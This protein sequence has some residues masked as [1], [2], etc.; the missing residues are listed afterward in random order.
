MKCT[1]IIL[2]I[3]SYSAFAQP[4]NFKLYNTANG[5]S[6]NNVSSI[7]KD[8][9][10]FIWVGT[11]NGLNRFD[12]NAFD[13]F[14]N[15]PNDSNTIASNYIQSV[16][17]TAKDKLWV[18]TAN[19]ISTFN[20]T[21]QH[22]SNY[23]PDTLAMPKIGQTFTCIE[24]DANN[25]I[26]VGGWYDLLIFNPT[27]KKFKTSG[28]ANYIQKVKP[29]NGNHRRVVI[30]S[31]YKKSNNSFWVLT[32]YGLFSVDINSLEFNFYPYNKIDDYYGCSISYVD[33]RQ[34]LW[35]ATY[36]KG[37]VNFDVLNQK[38]TNYPL[39][40]AYA[41][42]AGWNNANSIQQYN[43]DTLIV[44]SNKCILL[45]DKAQQKFLNTITQKEYSELPPNTINYIYK[46]DKSFWI[47]SNYGITN[48]QPSKNNF[49]FTSLGNTQ[50]VYR[51]FYSSSKKEFAL[52]DFF[53]QSG[54]YNPQT[55]KYTRLKTNPAAKENGVRAYLEINKDSAYLCTDENLYF[56]NPST[57][58]IKELS[59]PSKVI[60]ENPSTIRNIVKD[61][62][63]VLWIRI[64]SQGI[65]KYNPTLQTGAYVNI[66]P[67]EP[68]TDYSA[69]YYDKVS[70]CIF[71]AASNQGIYIYDIEKNNIKKHLLNI[72]PSQKGASISCIVGD[73]DGNIFLSDTYNGL[74][75][76]NS[77]NN[78]FKRYTIFDG[79]QSNNCS[80][81][82]VDNK[83]IW[84][85][86]NTG[87]SAFD[88]KTHQFK[89]FG[90]GQNHIGFA[91]YVTTDGEGN[92]YQPLQNGYLSWST[93]NV[94]QPGPIGKIY[95]RQCVVNEKLERIDSVYS[96]TADK[97]NVSFLFGYLL[98]NNNSPVQFEYLLNDKN[99]NAVGI[100]NKISFSKLPPNSYTLQ[101][102][103]KSNP[104]QI[105]TIN[106]TIVPPFYKKWWFVAIA[107]ICLSLLIY[108][109]VKNRITSIKKQ[110]TLKQKIAETEM[111]A[112]RAQMNP[113][114][115]FNAISSIDNFILDND[116]TNASNYLNKFAKLIRNILDNSK[117]EVVPFWKDWETL[118][119][120]LQLEQLR[121][122][123]SFAYTLHADENLL[124]GHYKIPPLIIQP[125]IENAIHHGL[126]PLQ[127][128]KGKLT[129]TATIQNNILQYTIEDNGIGRKRAAENSMVKSQH[130]SYGMQLTQQRIDLFNNQQ[131]N[132]VTIKDIE[133]G[134]KTGTIV[135]VFLKV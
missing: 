108:L 4:Y 91:D 23:S 118:N 134:D 69:L 39:P 77:I 28:W 123:D 30:L 75:V 26:W 9:K 44:A 47:L 127:N 100:N 64:R 74:I 20:E 132:N 7:I 31:I 67:V 88:I 112:L 21:T 48:M 65:Y 105:F 1:A 129:I 94:L 133:D 18:T 122:N 126:K 97:N 116:A 43:A 124:N 71:V 19:G 59:L 131:Q 72:E 114:F 55:K 78:T 50:M 14:Y 58:T 52:G 128:K 110:A 79:L 3:F 125:Y 120:Y 24:E 86:T 83:I 42:I 34:N 106:F 70:N 41:A 130:Q 119:L 84:I 101:V 45:F 15:N 5:L 109:L 46:D 51:M 92:I 40:T 36:D 103:E 37:L 66:A 2:L 87:V 12:G 16:Y 113:H 76:F 63:G 32:T 135:T 80:W 68:S 107:A 117:N 8:K 73:N 13:V 89:N 102:R 98:Q 82:C 115:I 104:Q 22:F 60:N 56:V 33:E 96:F 54:Y 121:S 111:M 6:S 90:K 27:T 53:T 35:I 62:T 99:W 93:N 61:K 95:L 10:N 17:I 81:L 85:A 29:I 49:N 11:Q 38:W 25:N 57:N